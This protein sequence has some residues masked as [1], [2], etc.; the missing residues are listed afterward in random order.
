MLA[1]G[2]DTHKPLVPIAGTPLLE[3]N[4]RLL[5]RWGLTSVVVSMSSA[6]GPV[7]E[8]CGSR[9]E[10]VVKAGGGDLELLV[11]AAPM[12][13]I[14]S[15]GLLAGRAEDVL[16][17]FADNLTTLDLRRLLAHHRSTS[18]ALTLAC[19][20]HR[21]RIPYG[22]LETEGGRVTGYVE[23]PVVPITVASAV[24]VLGAPALSLLAAW[25]DPGG[26]GLVDLTRAL[27]AENR[28]VAAYPH[29][30]DWVDVND[31][32]AIERADALVLRHPRLFPPH[33]DA[34]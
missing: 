6:D 3:H 13:N 16:V 20:E 7:A 18:A 29:A 22:Q 19:H 32:R 21:F 14:G 30:A 33:P 5:L 34:E 23:K 31:A 15:A 11:E 27:L 24:S 17:V 2:V 26:V 12:G 8:F 4:V 28:L 10:A 25:P 1:S 9:L